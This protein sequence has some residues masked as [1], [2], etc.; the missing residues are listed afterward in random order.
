MSGVAI[1][2]ETNMANFSQISSTCCPA[3]L[4]LNF[5]PEAFSGC[6][7]EDHVAESLLV[8]GVMQSVPI[9]GGKDAIQ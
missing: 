9:S 5:I 8:Q 6:P 4:F 7:V 2:L 1:T 3:I